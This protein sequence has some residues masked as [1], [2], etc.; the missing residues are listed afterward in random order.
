MAF[1]DLLIRTNAVFR[2]VGV[3][4]HKEAV[5]KLKAGEALVLEYEDDNPHDANAIRIRTL[6]GAPIGYVPSDMARRVRTDQVGPAF[7][8]VVERERTFEDVV[9]GVDIRVT[10]VTALPQGDAAEEIVSSS[11]AVASSPF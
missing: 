11:G 6:D 8:A 5:S 2:V 1:V 4:F 10:G 3:S 7:S 9:V